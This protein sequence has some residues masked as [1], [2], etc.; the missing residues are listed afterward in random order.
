MHSHH[1]HSG[2]FCQHAADTLE[3]MVLRAIDLQL[4]LFCLTEHMPRYDV[5][6]L[7]PEELESKTTTEDLERT[8][9][10]YITEA[11]RL[12]EKYKDKIDII[13]GFEG[14]AINSEYTKYINNIFAQYKP[15]YFIGSLHHTSGVPIDFDQEN[16][17]YALTHSATDAKLINKLGGINNL[18]LTYFT[19][20]KKFITEVDPK[21]AVIGHLDLITLYSR[22]VKILKVPLLID[23]IGDLIKAAIE[24]NCLFE[25]NSSGVRK[26]RAPYPDTLVAKMIIDLGGKFCLSDDSHNVDQVALNYSIVCDYVQELGIDTLWR[27]KLVDNKITHESFPVTDF[28][29]WVEKINPPSTT[30]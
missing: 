5:V 18:F 14:E 6:D 22:G 13:V 20:F 3:E 25:I 28:R 12:Q 8:F 2:Q 19:E 21:P 23:A 24:S 11:R 29:N 16:W 15:D 26:G 30:K 27:L 7:Y 4:S 1:S 10:A 9:S 17:E